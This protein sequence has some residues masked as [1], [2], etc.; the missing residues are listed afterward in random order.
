M[1]LRDTSYLA[2]RLRRG[3]VE[4]PGAD[5]WLRLFGCEKLFRGADQR[6]EALGGRGGQRQGWVVVPLDTDGAVL[7]GDD[8]VAGVTRASRW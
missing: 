1:S 3:D 6:H 2:A 5:P 7:Q 4:P 8:V